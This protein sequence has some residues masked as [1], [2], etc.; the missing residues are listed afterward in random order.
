M[1]WWM[2]VV[3]WTALVVLSAVFLA[4]MLYRIWRKLARALHDLGDFGD[5]VNERL[6]V[7]TAADGARHPM[8]RRADVYTPWGEAHRQYR[9]GKLERR[10]AR[11]QRR[12]ARR[13]A[14]G[15]PQRVSDLTR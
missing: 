5:S 12:S 8:P 4:L 15:Q 6:E 14:M 13:R 9:S 11:S 10:K 2:W 1:S 7:A 3:L